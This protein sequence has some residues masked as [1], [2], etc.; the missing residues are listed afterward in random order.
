MNVFANRMLRAVSKKLLG[1]TRCS[2]A[3]ATTN[4]TSCYSIGVTD[5]ND[6]DDCATFFEM[7]ELFYDKGS[8]LG[9]AVLTL[10]ARILD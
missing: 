9:K 4:Q 3:L 10:S 5:P 7:V 8:V 2:P 6:P 1:Q